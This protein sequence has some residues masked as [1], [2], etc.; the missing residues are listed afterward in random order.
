M[1]PD[2]VQIDGLEDLAAVADEA[3]GRV[4][5]L[6]PEHHADILGGIVGH[7]DAA[8][9]PVHDADAVAVA[10]ADGEVGAFLRTRGME[11]QQ[12]V[13]VVGKV[14]VHLE[15]V[16]V[17]PVQGP[18]EPR[19]VGRAEA[20]L[21]APFQQMEPF[22]EFPLQPLHD[23]GGAVRR[24]VVDDEDVKTTGKGEHLADDRFD[25]LLLV[26]GRYDDDFAVHYFLLSTS[27]SISLTA[28]SSW[29]SLPAR[30]EAGS[31]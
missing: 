15:D 5:D 10:G 17:A 21:A 26:V 23:G 3:G 28:A 2:L 8:Q 19:Q 13:G 11:P 30:T 1:H 16:V 22:G 6:H 4:L 18:F 12:V 7:D 9:G 31:L 25:V 14:R 24:A 27:L 20:E 29:R